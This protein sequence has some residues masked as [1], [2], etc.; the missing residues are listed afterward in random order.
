MGQVRCALGLL[1]Y[2]NKVAGQCNKT[3]G[4]AYSH[5]IAKTN[6]YMCIFFSCVTTQLLR[7]IKP[8]RKNDKETHGGNQ[9]GRY[10]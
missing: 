4:V 9:T 10:R 8:A 6:R 1:G 3:G 2:E 5:N 7:F